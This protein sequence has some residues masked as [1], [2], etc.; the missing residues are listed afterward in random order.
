MSEAASADA[1]AADADDRA[2][3]GGLPGITDP[4]FEK[5]RIAP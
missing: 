1:T 4:P 2:L 3:A 5:P